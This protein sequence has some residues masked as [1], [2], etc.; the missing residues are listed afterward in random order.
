MIGALFV[1]LAVIRFY[2]I[3]LNWT[4]VT[5]QWQAFLIFCVVSPV[6]EEVLFR[7]YCQRYLASSKMGQKSWHWISA[8]NLITT[9][10][11]ALTHAIMRDGITALL[12]LLPSL[13]LGMIKDR[14]QSLVLCIL[15]HAFW[16]MGWFIVV[17]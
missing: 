11:F 8:A 1:W 2:D 3:K 15:V 4:E 10:L 16:N 9:A 13:Y 17:Y 12:V 14:T 5:E 6:I 7:G